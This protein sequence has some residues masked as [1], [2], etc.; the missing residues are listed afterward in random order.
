MP[1]YTDIIKCYH[2]RG[3]GP[4]VVVIPI[5]I[6]QELKIHAGDRFLVSFDKQKRLVFQRIVDC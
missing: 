1:R 2:A 5:Q 3:N 4:L 6:R